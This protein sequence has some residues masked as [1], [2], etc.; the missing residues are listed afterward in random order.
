MALTR[1]DERGVSMVEL[2]VALAVFGLFFLL[3]DTVFISTHRSSRK[4]ELAA[5]VQQNAR[6]AVERLT[7]EIRESRSTMVR[8]GGTSPA[9][10]VVF[11][12][13]R[14]SA[15]PAVFCLYV[16]SSTDPNFNASCFYAGLTGPPT[17]A[18]FTYPTPPPANLVCTDP[19]NTYGSYQPIWQQYIGYYPQTV[20]GG[21]YQLLRVATALISP[22]SALPDPMTL[23]GGQVIAT[24]VQSFAVSASGSN[25][26]VTL[27]AQ[28]QKIV[29][30]TPVPTQ[31]I[32]LKGTTLL[33]N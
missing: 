10:G 21:G 32:F 11:T 27:D 33:R 17:T 4:A 2:L 16:R 31:E 20:S 14:L 13:A 5:D 19:T 18:P 26:S 3:I 7:R 24:Y 8:I 28:G 6:I 29:Q 9:M 30:G 25:I 23:T 22:C 1:R 15:N 12:S